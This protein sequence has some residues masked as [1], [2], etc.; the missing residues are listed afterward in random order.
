MYG[1]KTLSSWQSHQYNPGAVAM[2]DNKV[3]P[4]Y[5]CFLSAILQIRARAIFLAYGKKKALLCFKF[6]VGPQLGRIERC[7]EPGKEKTTN[8]SD[9]IYQ[10]T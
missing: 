1:D 2:D 5:S 8:W 10:L 6:V 3:G 7:I 4:S 9:I